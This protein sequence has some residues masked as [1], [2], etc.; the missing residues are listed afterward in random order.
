M[1]REVDILKCA[2]MVDVF[3]PLFRSVEGTVVKSHSFLGASCLPK[4][5]IA[6]RTVANNCARHKS[7]CAQDEQLGVERADLH[8]TEHSGNDE[9]STSNSLN[10]KSSGC[11]RPNLTCRVKSIAFNMSF[12]RRPDGLLS[13]TAKG[14][15]PRSILART[16]FQL[17]RSGRAAPLYLLT[18][19]MDQ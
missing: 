2:R 9:T 15:A 12:Q 14:T 5:K 1:S 4:P 16:I 17:E 13:R 19:T 18:P 3:R 10:N 8:A 7:Q 6:S 11:K